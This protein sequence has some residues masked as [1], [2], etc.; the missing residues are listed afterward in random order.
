L[1]NLKNLEVI[2]LNGTPAELPKSLKDKTTETKKRL[3]FILE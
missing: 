1:G 2:S 3:Y